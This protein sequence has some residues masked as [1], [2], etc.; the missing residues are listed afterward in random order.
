VGKIIHGL[1][2]IKLAR[3]YSS[4]SK[5]H[6]HKTGLF[7]LFAKILKDLRNTAK[8]PYFGV[9]SEFNESTDHPHAKAEKTTLLT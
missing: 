4:F 7:G 6:N 5:R 1:N 2:Y 8:S 9:F 3:V